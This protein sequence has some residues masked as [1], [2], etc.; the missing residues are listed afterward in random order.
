MKVLDYKSGNTVFDLVKL[1]YGTQLQLAVYMDAVM[2]QKKEALKQVSVEPGG[3]LYYHIDDPVIDLKDVTPGTEM[4]EEE[5]KAADYQMKAAAYRFYKHCTMDDKGFITCNVT[6]GAELKI[7][8]EV[9]EFRLRDMKG[10]N[11]MIKEN[12][13]DGARYRIIRID[14]ERYLNGLLNYK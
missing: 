5:I 12:I 11:E 3:M 13:R 14:D 6:N 4:S 1:Y 7:S 9:F 10:W 8:E 2:E